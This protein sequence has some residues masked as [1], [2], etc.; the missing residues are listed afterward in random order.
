MV[1]PKADSTP[2]IASGP[3]TL[4][5]IIG[6]HGVAGEVRLKVFADD[7]SPFTRFNDGALTLTSLRPGNNGAIARFA[8]I[9][10]RNAAEAMR[11]TTLTVPRSELP[12]LAEGEYYHADLIG[13]PAVT[14]TGEPLGT[15]VAVDNFGAGDVIEVE[16]PTG[17]R[18]MVPMRPEAVPEWSPERMVIEPD[19]AA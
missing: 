17:K 13:L 6:A 16:R 9:R 2:P 11:G 19:F 5:A 4:A 3:V 7:L 18:F 12:P 8:E 15:V 1:P 10:D 14:P